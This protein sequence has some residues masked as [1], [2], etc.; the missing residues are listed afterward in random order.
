MS[1]VLPGRHA[2]RHQGRLPA[3]DERQRK[4]PPGECARKKNVGS[5]GGGESGVSR[6]L[7]PVIGRG[8]AF[9]RPPLNY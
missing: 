5:A 2:E 8:V 1:A 9:Q 3:P 6:N 7:S 4:L